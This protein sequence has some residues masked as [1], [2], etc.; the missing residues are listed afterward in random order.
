MRLTSRTAPRHGEFNFEQ[1][2]LLQ[3]SHTHYLT[4]II[5][6]H[7]CG[8]PGTDAK[9][10]WGAKPWGDTRSGRWVLSH[11]WCSCPASLCAAEV[12]VT[13]AYH[14]RRSPATL[15][16]PLHIP[17]GGPQPPGESLARTVTRGP[18]SF[19]DAATPCSDPSG[20]TPVSSRRAGATQAR[21]PALQSLEQIGAVVAR[22]GQL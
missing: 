6:P 21:H 4:C 7:R 3:F 13:E 5:L 14:E 11:G 10:C 9:L 20:K 12:Q 18:S 19:G 16:E 17:R 1:S 8:I 2:F 22:A 15:R